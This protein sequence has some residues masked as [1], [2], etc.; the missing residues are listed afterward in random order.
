[1]KEKVAALAQKTEITTVR[2]ALQKLALTSPTSGGR[3]VGVVC[4][5]IQAT[6]FVSSIMAM[7]LRCHKLV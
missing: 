5:R 2:D 3:S 1:M 6:Q 4:S 7:W